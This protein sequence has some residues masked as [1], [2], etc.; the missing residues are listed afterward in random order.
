MILATLFNP[1]KTQ[2][3]CEPHL[4]QSGVVDKTGCQVRA[5]VGPAF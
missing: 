2:L 3:L 1:R 5:G 4:W